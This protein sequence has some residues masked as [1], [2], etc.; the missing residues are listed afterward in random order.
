MGTELEERGWKEVWSFVTTWMNL[1]DMATWA[2]H[3][4]EYG[5]ILFLRR[6]SNCQTQRSREKKILL[7]GGWEWGGDRRNCGRAV[8]IHKRQLERNLRTASPEPLACHDRLCWPES[9]QYSLRLWPSFYSV[10]SQVACLLVSQ[11]CL[12]IT[13]I[14]FLSPSFQIRSTEGG[15]KVAFKKSAPTE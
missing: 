10:R 1:E 13:A 15:E 9:A 7:H 4:N 6:N 11:Y 3:R 8:K 5:M 14:P 12:Q 2:M